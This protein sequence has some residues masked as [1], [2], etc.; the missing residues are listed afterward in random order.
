MKKTLLEKVLPR[1]FTSRA[2]LVS[3][4]GIAGCTTNNYYNYGL[5][6][7][8]TDGGVATDGSTDGG[9][10]SSVGD[11]SLVD[12][13]ASGSDT[14]TAI[15]SGVDVSDAGPVIC[16]GFGF[17]T[18]V[19]SSVGQ[20]VHAR[21]FT[22]FSVPAMTYGVTDVVASGVESTGTTGEFD[23]APITEAGSR[24]VNAFVVDFAGRRSD[25]TGSFPIT[26]R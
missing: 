5:D 20:V 11:S 12:A 9:D 25:C 6:A 18:G 22:S 2:A 14:G 4:L 19:P 1:S 23:T 13:G 21:V 7:G 16:S 17:P 8:F 24:S 3:I 26:V 15:D 10:A